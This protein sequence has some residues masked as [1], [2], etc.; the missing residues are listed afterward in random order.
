MVY[1]PGKDMA[2][3]MVPGPGTAVEEA[4]AGRNLNET[5]DLNRS[6]RGGDAGRAET[7]DVIPEAEY[8]RQGDR[9]GRPQAPGGAGVLTGANS[10]Q[11]GAGRKK[12]TALFVPVTPRTGKSA[13]T[14]HQEGNRRVQLP[15][16][17]IPLQELDRALVQGAGSNNQAS[18]RQRN[19]LEQTNP[20]HRDN[21]P[22]VSEAIINPSEPRDGEEARDL[23]QAQ[24]LG[25]DIQR[26]V[27]DARR[28]LEG[29]EQVE[30]RILG[31]QV[32]GVGARE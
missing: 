20:S 32:G 23:L 12:G 26:L 21:R 25:R 15:T 17:P 27:Q 31:T 13:S 22:A 19:T 11:Q 24:N 10:T 16:E 3:S 14:T 1:Q 30:A 28:V 5:I 7:P 29:E 8:S 9:Q 4:G 2:G 6:S 18:D